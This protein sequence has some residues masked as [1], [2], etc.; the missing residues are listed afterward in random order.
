M[1]MKEAI[2]GTMRIT[3]A[4]CLRMMFD[5]GRCPVQGR[6]LNGHGAK[7]KQEQLDHR[8]RPKAAVCQ[9]T[10]KTNGHP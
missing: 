6:S 8:V 5:V 10:V 1:R 3:W 2:Q 9:H 4:I 7:H